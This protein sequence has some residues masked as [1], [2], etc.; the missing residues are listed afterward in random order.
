MA[1]ITEG[2][3]F[4]TVAREW[5]CKWS[6]D[7]DKKSLAEAQKALNEILAEVK[8]VDGFKKVDRVVCGGCLDFKVSNTKIYKRV[9]ALWYMVV[10][11]QLQAYDWT[12][13]VFYFVLHPNPSFYFRLSHPFQQEKSLQHG[14]PI[15]LLPK[16]HFWRNLN[17]STGFPPLRHRLTRSCQCKGCFLVGGHFLGW[18]AFFSHHSID[19]EWFPRLAFFLFINSIAAVPGCPMNDTIVSSS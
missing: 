18:I 12:Q 13:M 8:A 19:D 10:Y 5:R 2:V 4:D 17:P 7:N 3:D 14:T 6:P 11:T 1:T 9:T 16:K 15:N